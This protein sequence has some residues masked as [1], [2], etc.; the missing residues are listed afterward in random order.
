MNQSQQPDHQVIII[1]TGFA[2]LG[3]AINLKKAGKEDFVI[4]ER[5]ADVGG[6][7]F[8]NNYPGC[9]CDVQSHLYS[10]SF[11][12]NPEWSRMFSPQE[13]IWSYLR[14]CTDKFDIRSHIRFNSEVSS[15]RYDEEAGIWTVT[16][17][18]GDSATARVVVSAMGPLD[19]PMLPNIPGI[20]S[21]KGKAFHSQHWDHDYDLSGKKVAVIGTGASAIQF[22]PEIATQVDEL[23]LFQ[24]TPPWIMPKP[25]RDLSTLEHQLYKR[26]P[27]A[28]KAMRGAI[29]SLLESRVLA[30][31]FTPRLMKMLRT[32]A[33]RHIHKHIKDPV[34]RAKVTPDY[35]IGC[36]RVLISNNYYPALARDN[37]D[38][39]TDGV[40]E[41]RANSVVTTDG[42]AH[43]VDAIIY[44]TGFHATEPLPRGVVFGKGGQDLLDAWADGIEAYKG[45]VVSGFPNLFIV[46]G[47]NTGLGHSS[48]VYMI[49]SQIRYVMG[50]LRTLDKRAAKSI[51]VRP[52]A[53]RAYN[54]DIQ[55][56]IQGTVWNT[57]GCQ[58]WYINE[59][60]K[61]VTLWPGFTFAFRQRTRHFDAGSYIIEPIAAAS[62]ETATTANVTAPQAA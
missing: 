36:K 51:D 46:P 30:F 41:V 18:D 3:M 45:C 39:I 52:E 27:A 20:D 13:E 15:A 58:S 31:V 37:V 47:P 25:D 42:V 1:G 19:R 44:G 28:Q 60:G 48:M 10:F 14:D 22:V 12:P 55:N 8:V 40:A 43:A 53:Q 29:Y 24:R 9:A 54:D 6:T 57:G 11:A 5:E 35:T 38:V 56:R 4:F 26:L 23:K 16:T 7:W 34:L 21:F 50:A 62:N 2:G 32:V 33:V 59:D 17:A 61:N 49:E